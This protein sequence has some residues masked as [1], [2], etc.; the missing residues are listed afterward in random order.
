MAM[1]FPPGPAADPPAPKPNS[2]VSAAP[3]LDPALRP[4]IAELFTAFAA[5]SL[6]GFGGVL[7]WARRIMVEKRRWLTAEQFNEAF[8]LCAFLPGGNMVNFS[9]IFGSRLRGPL[10]ALAALAGLLGPP[11]VLITAVGALYAHYGDLPVLRRI[12][13]GVAAAAAGLMLATVAKMARPLFKKPFKNR[14]VI[15][16]VIALA[17]FTAIG[18]LHWP[19]PVVLAVIVPVSITAAWLQS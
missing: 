19:L 13:T 15:G 8:A 9:V 10:G 7:A 18:I 14:A 17:T 16:P 3:Q 12:L 6:S 4:T 2:K 1:N 5:I 11:M